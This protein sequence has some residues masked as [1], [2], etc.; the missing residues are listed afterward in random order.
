[1]T[2]YDSPWKEAL[3]LYF[4]P[5]LAFF[6]PLI[7]N[8]IDWSRGYESL[9][10]ELQKIAPKAAQ[11]RR[12]VDKLVKVWRKNGRSVWVL[13]H[14][15]VQTQKQHRFAKRVYVYNHRIS[16]YYD[17]T[18]VSLAV[19]ADDDPK[20]RPNQHKESLWGWSLEMKFPPAKLLD[21]ANCV[22]ELEA[23][24][25]PFAPIVLAHLKALETRQDPE[26]RQTWKFRLFRHLHERGFTA[27]DVRQLFRIIDW[28]MEL[29]P[30]LEDLLW[31]DIEQLQKEQPVPFITTP[32]RVG[33]RRGLMLA[34]EDALHA[35]FKKEGLALLPEI[36]ALHD[37][38]KYRVINQIIWQAKTLDEVR[39]V[40]AA[41]AAPPEP[42]KKKA[43]RKKE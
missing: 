19:L 21:Y 25:N 23:D 36:R 38:D 24:S 7:Y 9:D 2:D 3:D 30:A 41:A 11:G 4:Q 14:I 10:K 6:F 31:E 16:D 34:I 12:H 1:M 33:I 15:E 29:P 22:A 42:A 26:Q 37:A 39:Q 13:L 32:E 35:R 28:L 18:V 17:C 27:E 5:F 20:W 40:C 8:D 43:R